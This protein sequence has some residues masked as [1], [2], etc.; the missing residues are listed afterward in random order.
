MTL[1]GVTIL[2]ENKKIG[3]FFA[4]GFKKSSKFHCQKNFQSL[5]LL[6]FHLYKVWFYTCKQRFFRFGNGAKKS[7]SEDKKSDNGG[8]KS[9]N[10]I[11]FYCQKVAMENF[12]KKKI[13]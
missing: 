11:I 8:K 7:V 2:S 9:G 6:Y 13:F 3:H 4:I 5:I 12:Q 1:G 10:G